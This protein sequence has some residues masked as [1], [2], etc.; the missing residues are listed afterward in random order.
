MHKEDSDK[1]LEEV[2]ELCRNFFNL[3]Y[4][5]CNFYN[6]ESKPLLTAS[7]VMM[8]PSSYILVGKLPICTV[9]RFGHRLILSE[10]LPKY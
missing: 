9:D 4:K 2:S 3:K 8:T 5:V 6:H 1:I 7:D 10:I